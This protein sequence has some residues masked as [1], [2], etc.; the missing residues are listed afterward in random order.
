MINWVV[1]EQGLHNDGS[2][3]WTDS[4]SHPEKSADDPIYYRIRTEE[5][6]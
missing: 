6:L 5:E 4:S 3:E 1:I 2:T